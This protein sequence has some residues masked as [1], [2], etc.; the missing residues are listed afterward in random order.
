[1]N[2]SLQNSNNSGNEYGNDCHLNSIFG[3]PANHTHKLDNFKSAIKATDY[4]FA[5]CHMIVLITLIAYI[6]LS[7]VRKHRISTFQWTFLINLICVELFCII[8]Q[9][10]Y[11][12]LGDGDQHHC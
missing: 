4:A 1:M 6:T 5:T 11:F 2:H 9:F 8:V 12:G 7:M 3:D 10:N